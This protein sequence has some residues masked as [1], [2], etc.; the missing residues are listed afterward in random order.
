MSL[1]SWFK[2]SVPNDDEPLSS[3]ASDTTTDEEELAGSVSEQEEQAEPSAHSSSVE[4]SASA[5]ITLIPE[6][7]NQP[8]LSFPQR[9]I[10][11]Q[12]RS[13]CSSWYSKYK[14]L[15]YQEG[16][17]CVFCYYCL[18]AEL[19]NLPVSRYKDDIFWIF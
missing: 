16:A 5:S 12:K 17:D 2:K 7:P 3:S 13:F 6:K 14:W 4:Q 1:L 19:C 8:V 18:V 10:G 15:H 9:L 11:T